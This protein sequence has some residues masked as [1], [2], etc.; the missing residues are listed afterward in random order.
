M[1]FKLSFLSIAL[2]FSVLTY[3]PF[4]IQGPWMRPGTMKLCVTDFKALYQRP[5]CAPPTCKV[6]VTVSFQGDGCQVTLT[7][8]QRGFWMY[9]TSYSSQIHCKVKVMLYN[10]HFIVVSDILVSSC[11]S[12]CPWRCLSVDKIISAF[13]F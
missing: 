9:I 12:V 1:T 4:L 5:T 3:L 8:H 11:L 2:T 7:Q 13:Q 10:I 6:K